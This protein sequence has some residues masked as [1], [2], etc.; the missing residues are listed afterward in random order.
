MSRRAVVTIALSAIAFT[1]NAATLESYGKLPYYEEVALSPDGV[2]VAF[3]TTLGEERTVI[4]QNLSDAK[5]TV[6]L[7][8]GD[9]KL[10]DLSW[11]GPGHLLIVSSQT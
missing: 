1:V 2:R 5:D 6:R 11:A 3:V 10:R 7:R 8:A 9:H 4:I